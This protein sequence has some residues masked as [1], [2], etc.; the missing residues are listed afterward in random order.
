VSDFFRFDD[1]RTITILIGAWIVVAATGVMWGIP[2]I[3]TGIRANVEA[4][5]DDPSL[6]VTV[7]G[8]NVVLTS[9]A[10]DAS[11]ELARE[12]ALSVSGV[13]RVTL[14]QDPGAQSILTVNPS[15]SGAPH[16]P[17]LVDPTV[18]V[19]VGRDGVVLSGSVSDSATIDA[20]TAATVA[21]FGQER[22]TVEMSVNEDTLEPAWLADPFPLMAAIGPH[23]LGIQIYDKTLR[24]TGAVPDEN[25]Q[26]EVILSVEEHVGSQLAVADRLVI[27]P[28]ENPDFLMHSNRGNVTLRGTVR[29]QGQ[30]NSISDSA[31]RIYGKD[32]VAA[33]LTVDPNGPALGYLTDSEAFFRSLEGRTLDFV[34][35]GDQL[36]LRGTVP[37]QEIADSIVE[38]LT[39][40]ADPRFVTNELEVVAIDSATQNAIDE[41][42]DIIGAA[43]NFG[44]GSTSLNNDD[45]DK[46]DEVAA[47]FDANP[48]LRA[49]IEG[50]TDDLGSALGNQRISEERAKAVVVYLTS[51]GIDSDRLT[52]LGYGEERPIASNGSKAGRA[53][54]R[55]IEF[56]VEG[57]L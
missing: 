12:A 9:A 52:T 3:E 29:S 24:V 28:I 14:V 47:I 17:V 55:R 23:D 6:L 45:R 50:H 57:S 11:M 44:S 8:R 54:N 43:L 49:I 2:R 4:A 35:T 40:V 37:T 5:I 38:A 34:D 21:A 20:L 39:A 7:S 13:R 56:N 16:D 25:V 31:E 51:L 19:T 1:R 22:V 18:T 33:W 46:L 27:V 53:L 10:T 48:Q 32:S 30:V 26:T 15:D 41:I 36:I 42:N